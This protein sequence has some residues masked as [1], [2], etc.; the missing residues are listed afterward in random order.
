MTLTAPPG[1]PRPSDP[2]THEEFDALVEALIEEARQRQRR[3]RRRYSAALAVVALVGVVLFAMLGRS[4]QSQ[5]ASSGL[6]ARLSLS[7]ATASSKIAFISEP[8]G[9]GYCGV[10]YVMNADG[11]GQR[12]LT[13]GGAPTGCGQEHRPAWSPDGRRMAFVRHDPQFGISGPPDIWVMNVDGTAGRRV[14]RNVGWSVP[15]WS[16]DRRRIAFVGGRGNPGLWVVNADGSGQSRL[17]R[18][19]A[20]LTS[21]PVWSPDGGRIAFVGWRDGNFG[22][23]NLEI[24]VIN[25][26]GSGQR[27]LTRNTAQDRDP[28]WSADGRRIAYVSNGQLY[29][30]NAD[31]SRQRR[32]TRTNG[33]RNVAPAWSPDGRRIAFERR[34]GRQDH[35]GTPLEYGQCS[36][37]IER[38]S[39]QVYV[40]NS[41]GSEARK[42]AE[43]S[44]APVWSPDG[45]KIAFEMQDARMQSDIYV[46]NADG[47]G[48]RNLTRSAGRRESLP[49]WSPSLE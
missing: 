43:R 36:R 3:R 26:D 29:V 35:R 8:P 6:A 11:S 28:V 30:I 18:H 49:V 20:S 39:S 38:L 31:G 21:A 44:G 10:V 7:A 14:A 2:V 40:M 41:D 32:L 37:C 1:Q 15:A 24:Y 34:V 47:S 17:T 16:P 19:A 4:A 46:M 48:K 9:G 25:A 27:R 33:A 45:R 13:N 5:T 23:H 12:R 22:S 42:L